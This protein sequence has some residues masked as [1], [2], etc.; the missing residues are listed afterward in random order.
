MT[1][2]QQALSIAIFPATATWGRTLLRQKKR[3]CAGK[4]GMNSIRP[5]RRLQGITNINKRKTHEDRIEI[6]EKNCPI[7]Y[8]G[9][10][11]IAH[12]GLRSAA[13]AR[14]DALPEPL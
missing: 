8:R 13:A 14:E 11:H 5:P 3:G 12:N 1:I 6:K 4:S 10:Y 9:D 7:R 2:C